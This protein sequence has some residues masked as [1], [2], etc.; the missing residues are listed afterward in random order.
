[1]TAISEIAGM[2]SDAIAMQDIFT[3]DRTGIR[4]DGRVTGRFRATGIRPRCSD[5]ISSAGIRMSGDMFEH[6]HIIS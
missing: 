2:E 3:F 1:V 6:T 4:P 5:R